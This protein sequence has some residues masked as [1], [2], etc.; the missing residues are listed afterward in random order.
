[1]SD[2]RKELIDGLN[3]DLAAE[4]EAIIHYAVGAEMMTGV[5]REEL[6]EFFR[7]EVDDEV[8]HARILAHKIVALGGT[9]TTQPRD[10]EP[11]GTNRERLE[12]ALAA[13][14]ETIQRYSQR[15]EQADAVGDLGLRVQLEDLIADETRHMHDLELILR[16][17]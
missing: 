7:S 1:M 14:K 9:P 3:E 17:S 4:L 5:H 2:A 12:R 16:D 10:V 13:E 11:G 15:L 8:E 6:R